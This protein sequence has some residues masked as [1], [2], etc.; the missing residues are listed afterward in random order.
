LPQ[1]RPGFAVQQEIRKKIREKSPCR[2][3]Q[4][5]CAGFML[6]LPMCNSHDRTRDRNNAA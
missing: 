1:S 6:D 4:A 3:A 2:F 5:S